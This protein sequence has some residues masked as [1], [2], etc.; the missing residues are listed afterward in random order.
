MKAMNIIEEE[1]VF[2]LVMGVEQIIPTEK[3]HVKF[4][5]FCQLSE[6]VMSWRDLIKYRNKQQ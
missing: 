5:V 1:T 3:I 6:I 4:K 2:V